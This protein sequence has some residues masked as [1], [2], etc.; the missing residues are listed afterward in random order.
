MMGDQG[1]QSYAFSTNG[2]ECGKNTAWKYC[3]VERNSTHFYG[4]LPIPAGKC[5]E[6]GPDGTFHLFE[7]DISAMA[8]VDLWGRC[9][10]L[11]LNVL[12]NLRKTLDIIFLVKNPLHILTVFTWE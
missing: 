6:T 5:P 10:C 11:Q 12:S 2:E 9:C 4:L 3:W 7:Q 8:P 1:G